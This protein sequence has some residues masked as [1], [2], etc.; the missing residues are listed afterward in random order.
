MSCD[1]FAHGMEVKAHRELIQAG[2]VI[3]EGAIGKIEKIDHD[4]HQID[5]RFEKFGLV[6]GLP[7]H[8]F[9]PVAAAGMA[10]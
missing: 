1:G 6:R 3:K 10:S 9:G 8:S 7:A 4:K 2:R 5:V